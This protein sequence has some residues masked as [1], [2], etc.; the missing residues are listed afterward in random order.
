MVMAKILIVDDSNL[1]RRILKSIL[2]AEG[3]EI[4]EASDGLAGIETYVIEQPDL[5][6]LDMAMPGMPGDEVLD[7]IMEVNPQ[8]RIIIATADLQELTKSKVLAA[9]AIGFLNKPFNRTK[10]LDSVNQG[11]ST[12]SEIL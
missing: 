6:L 7:K 8:A 4:I 3:H 10:V 5:V 2:A 11:L 12:I 9:G 1:S